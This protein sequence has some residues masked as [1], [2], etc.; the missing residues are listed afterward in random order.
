MASESL[1]ELIKALTPSERIAFKRSVKKT[2]AKYLLLF[3]CIAEMD[4]YDED[5]IRFKLRKATLVK[6]LAVAKHYLYQTL[7]EYFKHRNEG[8]GLESDL[9]RYLSEADFLFAK[10]LYLQATKILEK[11]RTLA[12]ETEEFELWKHILFRLRN[13]SFYLNDTKAQ[14]ETAAEELVVAAQMANLFEYIIL[15]NRY[16]RIMANSHVVH[17]EDSLKEIHDISQSPLLVDASY[18]QSTRAFL[19]YYQLKIYLATRVDDYIALDKYTEALLQYAEPFVRYIKYSPIAIFVSYDNVINTAIT[20][21][22]YPTVKRY[23][24]RIAAMQPRTEQHQLWK[25]WYYYKHLFT[26][27]DLVKDRQA[28]M[29]EIA[30]VVSFLKINR[31]TIVQEWYIALVY[32]PTVSLA[33]RGEWHQLIEMVD[34]FMSGYKSEMR[35]DLQFQIKFLTVLAFAEIG[36]TEYAYNQIANLNNYLLKWQI[37]DKFE[38]ILMRTIKVIC[39][40]DGNSHYEQIIRNIDEIFASDSNEI[41]KYGV[42]SIL[43]FIKIYLSSKVAKVSISSYYFDQQIDT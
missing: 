5:I 42:E 23:L 31:D 20:R 22:D 17:G 6:Q 15:F 35:K 19:F 34:L 9:Y 8:A 40:Q 29:D 38:Q 16:Y 26:Y 37:K 43:N 3:D 11:A 13:I 2:D 12:K 41:Y 24:D 21:T 33:L 32:C 1:F 14:D 10:G 27:L 25:D 18:P 39:M 30:G 4:E 36:Q 28:G 7:I